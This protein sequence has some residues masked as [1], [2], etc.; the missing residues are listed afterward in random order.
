MSTNYTG[1]DRGNKKNYQQ[2]LEAMDVI[3]VEKVASASVFFESQEDNT[4]VDIGMA[5]GM[6]TAI[7][8]KL[9]PQMQIIGV[10]INP[11]MV[12]IAQD[13]YNYPNLSF[14][15]DDGEKLRTFSENSVNGFFNCSAIH[16]I[17]SYNGYDTNRALNTLRRQVEL[18]KDKGVLVIRDFIKPEEQEVIIELSTI[19]KPSR[20]N[21]AELFIQFAQTA[22][23][24]ASANER[25][26]PIK[27]INT[28]KKDIRRFQA[29]YTDVV[30]FIRRKDYYANWDIEL[31]EEYGYFTQEDFEEIFRELGLRIILSSPIYNQWIINNRYKNQF[32]IYDLS[33]KEIGFPPTNYL[34]AGEKIYGG[35]QVQLIRHLPVREDSFLH[36]SSY[37]NLKTKK[38]YDVVERPNNVLDIIP[39]YRHENGFTILAKHGY[40][41]PL[42]NVKTDSFILDNKHY[43]G[44]IPEG[45]TIGEAENI[46]D[47]LNKR[48]GI[49][50]DHYINIFQSLNYYTSP[51]GINEKVVSKFIELTKPISVNKVSS[52]SFSGFKESG[53][54]H[55][56]D[57][58]QLLNTAQTGALV[59]ARLELNVYNL[60][61]KQ[62]I[63]LPKWLGE[64]MKIRFDRFIKPTSFSELLSLH[65]QDYEKSE[66]QAGFL[67]TRRAYFSE[68]GIENS[69]AIFEYVY[70]STVSSN[71]LVTL[72]VFKKDGQIYVGLEVQSLPVPQLHSESSTIITAPAKRL[73]KEVHNIHDL[74]E[75]ITNMRIGKGKIERYSKLGEK[76]FSS[77]GITT[78]QVYPYLVCLDRDDKSL[79]WA[80]LSDLYQNMDKIED[81]HLLI[82]LCRLIHATDFLPQQHVKD[83]SFENFSDFI[84]DNYNSRNKLSLTKETLVEKDLGITGDDSDEFLLAIQEEFEINFCYETGSIK[85]AFNLKKNEYFFHGEG[86]SLFDWGKYRIIPI[87]V[88]ELYDVVVKLSN[89]K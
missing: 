68:M 39:F 61:F 25:G 45:I 73:P 80:N 48:F 17:T 77:V 12:Q 38:I 34:I 51:G 87:T 29:F 54:I 56:Y 18:L 50:K 58:A 70:P 16:H 71:T 41:R 76:Y 31:Q 86:F 83:L 24:L 85:K 1:Q 11:K 14:R 9:F 44:Y 7:L 64:K 62:N 4:I 42:A 40:P 33:G 79:K 46:D 36:F 15:E 22:R 28:V 69:N 32:A 23:S 21:D 5:S 35:K 2:Y 72:P 59:E 65:T 6:S 53:Y 82:C 66:K 10:D 88:G 84:N 60:F 47:I 13:T 37:Q 57:A 74:E 20:P 89:E 75:Y 49:S 30:E 8:A 81:A 63:P 26:F 55:E 3:S 19:D 67:T 78:E 43:S 27:G 52:K